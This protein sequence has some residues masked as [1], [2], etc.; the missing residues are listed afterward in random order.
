MSLLGNGRQWP[1][2]QATRHYG[3][4]G[5]NA[6]SSTLAPGLD[7]RTRP[8][9]GRCRHWKW[10]ARLA[11]L[12]AALALVA[13]HVN[14][15]D[16]AG[17]FGRMTPVSLALVVGVLTPLAIWLRSVR[18]RYLLGGG[19]RQHVLA[20]VRAY[21]IGTL[22]N[23]LLLGKFGDFVK[24][25]A[26]CDAELDYGRSV[27][28]VVI[29][30]LLEG[31]ALI[32]IF[33]GVLLVSP[34]PAWTH[35]LA[36]LAGAACLVLL[37]LMRSAMGRHDQVLGLLRPV[38]GRLPAWLAGRIELLAGQVVAGCEP[39]GNARRLAGAL[40]LGLAVWSVEIA[41]VTVFLK[42]FAVGAPWLVAAVILLVVLNLGML[43]PVSPGSVGVYQLLCAFGLALW[44]VKHDVG[45]AL[46][47]VMQ[48]VLFLPL[49]LAGLAALG[50]QRWGRAGR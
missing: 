26:I 3:D 46:G 18:W 14:L 10:P 27:A 20:Y 42:E 34:L 36:W 39:L 22:A 12:G 50:L 28:V 8:E 6:A 9:R 4:Y 37:A 2:A 32:A 30:R 44:G 23:S 35:R 16:V 38:T 7:T 11:V 47:V 17:A 31:I 40:L 5:W 29:D 19:G 45:L 1:A 24:A 33:V 25:R 49:Y 15:G 43:V 41:S 13:T 48:T 21:L